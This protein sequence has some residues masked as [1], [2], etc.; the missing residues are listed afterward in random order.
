MDQE[1]RLHVDALVREHVAAGMPEDE[2]R[3]EARRRF[4]SVARLKERG[5]DIRGARLLED[6][7]RDA[8]LAARGLR[9]NPAFEAT[10]VLTLALGIGGNTSIF[11][12]VDQL[13]L[14]PLPYPAGDRLVTVHEVFR[15]QVTDASPANWLDWQRQSRMLQ[16]VAV[17]RA[18]SVTL[19][20]AGEPARVNEQLVSAEFFPLLGVQPFLGRTISQEDDLPD[21]PRVAVL[22][23]RLWQ[24]RFGADPN[25][26][27]RI[28]QVN[29]NR[30]EVVGVMPAGFQ[31]MYPDNDLWSAY[32]L[33]RNQQWRETDGRFV[34][35]VARLTPGTTHEAAQA[36]MAG[37][38]RSLADRY[39]FNRN[40]SVELV[41]LREELTGQVRASLLFL[42]GAVGVLF[43]IACFN[44]AN[45]LLAR[46]A[47][48]SRELAI[49]TSL[50]SGRV[51]LVRQLLVESLLLALL[52]GALGASLATWSLGALM[53]FAPGDLLPVRDVNVDQRILAYTFVLSVLTG[54]IVG[55]APSVA[56]MKSS[57]AAALRAT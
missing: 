49:R 9:R 14:R 19:T 13:L 35:A 23:Y 30:V 22:S 40:T 20:E 36:E 33:D 45:L 27:G 8:Q 11:S 16:D 21:A 3:R 1:M 55:I 32:R 25:A 5:H 48:R 15:G 26:V 29:D 24:Q 17:W 44:V 51:A 18:F 46:G 41:P 10:V 50:G 12:V 34:N 57:M 6:L 38:A 56:A 52:G 47:S 53:A 42:Y 28:V 31:F 4:G 37:I 2:A 39:D 54:T 43:A 7:M